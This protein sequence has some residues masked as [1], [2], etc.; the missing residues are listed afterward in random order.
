MVAY[1]ELCGWTLAKAHARSGDAIAIGSYLGSG[2]VFDKSMADVRRALRRPERARLRGAQGGGRLGSRGGGSRAIASGAG[3]CARR[4][5]I[6]PVRA[7]GGGA[8]SSA[9][10][11]VVSRCLLVASERGHDF[12][13]EVDPGLTGDVHCGLVDRSADECPG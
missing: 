9:A 5:R 13:L 12:L 2:D 1:A 4:M 6:R 11:R 10:G 3:A 7:T 8:R